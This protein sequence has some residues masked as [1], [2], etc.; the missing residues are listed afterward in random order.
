MKES[1]F[2]ACVEA[3][4]KGEASPAQLIAL[5]QAFH[6]NPAYLD[7]FLQQV[8]IDTLLRD[9]ELVIAGKPTLSRFGR[10]WPRFLAGAAG[11]AFLLGG[12]VYARQKLAA[13][14]EVSQ[15]PAVET[16]APIQSAPSI[17][18][19]VS[20][21]PVEPALPTNHE[22]AISAAITEGEGSMIKTQAVAA[23]A[24]ALT[25][26][27]LPENSVASAA[28][29]VEEPTA[30][31]VVESY[32]FPAASEDGVSIVSYSDWSFVDTRTRAIG[33]S[34]GK[35]TWTLSTRTPHGTLYTFQ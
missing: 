27:A 16:P 30:V 2:S 19:V 17:S 29:S 23:V 25:V 24:A 15:C 35:E 3:A 4:M 6:E 26:A 18:V 20:A 33:Y 13:V 22:A 14:P 1:I 32:A 12:F 5:K 28:T 9:R 10:F 7:E 21:P 31:A 8:S 11:L 34:A